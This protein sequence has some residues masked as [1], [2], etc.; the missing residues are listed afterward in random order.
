MWQVGWLKTHGAS[1]AISVDEDERTFM[2]DVER[3]QFLD[4]YLTNHVCR[5]GVARRPQSLLVLSRQKFKSTGL[6]TRVV[7]TYCPP[8]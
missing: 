5:R 6:H 3:F 1:L 8:T 2:A 4:I 7:C